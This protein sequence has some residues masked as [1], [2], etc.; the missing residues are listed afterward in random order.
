M[1]AAGALQDALDMRSP[2]LVATL[3]FAAT[4]A[5][6]ACVDDP[7]VDPGDPGVAPAPAVRLD[8]SRALYGAIE[9]GVAWPRDT[10]TVCWMPSALDSEFAS[11]R[12]AVQ[13][14]VDREWGATGRIRFVWSFTCDSIPNAD[15]RI[16]HD[17]AESGTSELG[18]LAQAVPV[19][20]PTMVIDLA[21]PP[22]GG[23]VVLP[24]GP[25]TPPTH[26]PRC[27]GVSGRG[28]PPSVDVWV[29][30]TA[31]HEFGHALGLRHE[32]ARNDPNCPDPETLDIP[33][34]N[35][36]RAYDGEGIWP[37]DQLSIMHYCRLGVLAYGT[38]DPHLSVGDLR[39]LHTLYPGVV[40]LFPNPELG[41]APIRLGPGYYTTATLSLGQVSS[42][43]V[44]PGFT[45]NACYATTPQPTCVP[46]TESVRALGP[47][48]DNRMTDILIAAG[49]SVYRD[50]GY[51]GVS[52]L[53]GPGT[54]RASQGQL[55]TV[56]NDAI[57]SA[58]VPPTA[59]MTLCTDDNVSGM[60]IFLPGGLF[61]TSG[62]A[63][64]NLLDNQMS[65][66]RVDPR[67]VTYSD[68]AFRGESWS[69]AVGTYRVS[70]GAT[71]LPAVR[72]L[73]IQGLKVTACTAEGPVSPFFG[74][75]CA[76]TCTTTQTS[77][78]TLTGIR[79]LKVMTL[80]ITSG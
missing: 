3:L 58:W 43:V 77:L 64:T 66:V 4:T 67:V 61:G 7:E 8:R 74:P 14:A 62:Y 31:L 40:A 38:A 37:L 1:A 59:A 79:C 52:Q 22:A 76:G 25:S 51:Q 30:A 20:S 9:R 78:A 27:D 70:A 32:H 45:V 68:A 80:P 72:A 28:T 23:C 29:I 44:P 47:A 48:L 69:L 10:L 18:T 2:T 63:L 15:I 33:A 55:A 65:S 56:G 34:Q 50:P 26:A 39:A 21:G 17:R 49:A 12:L 54:Y 71:W 46:Y 5:I 13:Q 53:L 60:C 42:F 57:S 75:T 6:S 24:G 19:G 11:R 36:D 16:G 35:G 73:A 41:G